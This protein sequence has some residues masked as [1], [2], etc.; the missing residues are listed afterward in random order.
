VHDTYIY[1]VT[2]INSKIMGVN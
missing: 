1:D 2:E